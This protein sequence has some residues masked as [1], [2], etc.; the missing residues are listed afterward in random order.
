[1]LVRDQVTPPQLLFG[2]AAEMGFQLGDVRVV[3]AEDGQVEALPRFETRILEFH[4]DAGRGPPQAKAQREGPAVDAAQND[5]SWRIGQLG[6][7]GVVG[8]S[9]IGGTAVPARVGDFGN[10][11]GQ[12]PRSPTRSR[13]SSMG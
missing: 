1:M 7:A 2:Y 13:T 12:G 3:R 10:R 11:R 4:L 5:R 8:N 9:G 6:I